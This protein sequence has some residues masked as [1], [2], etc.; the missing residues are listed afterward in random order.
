MGNIDFSF[1]LLVC[2]REVLYFHITLGRNPLQKQCTTLTCTALPIN[3]C[4]RKMRNNHIFPPTKFYFH[5]KSWHA[6][7]IIVIALLPLV[8]LTFHFFLLLSPEP[9]ELI[10]LTVHTPFSACEGRWNYF[11]LM[12]PRS[13]ASQPGRTWVSLVTVDS[14]QLDLMRLQYDSCFCING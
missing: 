11:E 3:A 13:W 5:S 7:L 10:L 4:I 6:A 8:S 9:K 12:H 2:L 1:A 14:L